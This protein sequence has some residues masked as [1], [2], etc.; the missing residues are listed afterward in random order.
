MADTLLFRGG[1]SSSINVSSVQNREIVIDTDTNQL[2]TGSSK[3]RTVMENPSSGNVDIEGR[4]TNGGN[5]LIGGVLPS[6]PLI[7]LNSDGSAKF[8]NITIASNGNYF[9]Q[10]NVYAGQNPFLGISA[11]S[12][13]SIGK[14]MGTNTGTASIWEGRNTESGSATTSFIRAN[15]SAVFKGSVA[16]GG[17]TAANT[18]DA[19]EEGT[20]TPQVQ[21]GGSNTGV[22]YGGRTGSYTRIGNQVTV[23]VYITLSNK[24]SA[25]GNA[26]IKPLPFTAA[27]ISASGLVGWPGVIAAR[28]QNFTNLS[29]NNPNI[30]V[31]AASNGV[32]LLLRTA[33]GVNLT[34]ANF[35]NGSI[36][37]FQISYTVS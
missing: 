11:G 15:G 23:Y 2:V 31:T 4:L 7:E 24:G 3:F 27:P 17:N 26:T 29:T 6:A 20:F 30:S 14:V 18:I 34:D 12:G 36:L 9:T 28:Q 8:P 10:A 25:S 5:V 19:Y 13:L 21:F 32:S 35:T 1:P 16:I 22:S 33:P 37:E